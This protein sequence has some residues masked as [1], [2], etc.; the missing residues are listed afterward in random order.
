[1]RQCA[2]KIYLFAAST[3]IQVSKHVDYNS[4]RVFAK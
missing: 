1:M 4:F 3:E 2:I